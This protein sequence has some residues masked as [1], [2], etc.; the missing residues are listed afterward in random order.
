MEFTK[1][2]NSLS[3][4]GLTS[5][6]LIAALTGCSDSSDNNNNPSSAD[7]LPQADNP[8]VEGPVTGGGADDCCKILD[9]FIDLRDLGYEPGTAFYA[10]TL[11]YPE[12]EVGYRETEYFISGMAHSYIA[13]DELGTDGIWSVAQAEAA[14]Y[15][16][17]IVVDRP[18][19][20]QNFNGTVVVEW[21]NV[22][23]GLDASPDWNHMHTE[24]TRSGYV[25]VGVSAQSAG[26]EG[27]GPSPIPIS[28]KQL[29]EERYGS[30]SH[31]GDSFSYDI[32]SQAAQS[33]RNPVGLDPLEG[34]QVQR[35]IGVGQSQLPR[36]PRQR[37]TEVCCGE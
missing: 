24:I 23:A 28:L 37:A 14:D 27:G 7:Q 5:L 13:T 31:P 34:L 2:R 1:T 35:M 15:K 18:I 33:V 6:V 9:G 32:F 10:R 21:F 25:W 4:M 3:A 22:T 20:P 17:R 11:S 29:D 8:V 36:R 26:V 30:L 19:D 16:V 12:E